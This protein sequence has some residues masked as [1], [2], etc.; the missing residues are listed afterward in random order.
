MSENL[1]ANKPS[2]YDPQEQSMA[3]G[4]AFLSETNPDLEEIIRAWPR[5]QKATRKRIMK[6]IQAAYV[7][8]QKPQKQ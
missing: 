3:R 4:M 6:Q 2:G 5:L 7:T 1:S 8:G